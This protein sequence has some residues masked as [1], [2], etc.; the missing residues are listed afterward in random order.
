MPELAGRERCTGCTACA[1]VCLVSC[2]RMER[3][4]EGFLQP[5]AGDACIGCGACERVC[6][7][8]N[9]IEGNAVD[10]QEAVAA[11]CRDEGLWQ[12]S[13]SGGAFTC[14]CEEFAAM[15][16]GVETVVYGAS[17]QFPEVRHVRC[18]ASDVAPLRK[19][20]YVQSDKGDALRRVRDD[21]KAGRR[22]VFS[23]T[24]CEVAALYSYLGGLAQSEDILLVDLVCHG[25]GSPAVFERCMERASARM[26]EVTGYEFRCKRPVAGNYERYLSMYKYL[27]KCLNAKTKYVRVD[28]YNRL[29]L[30]QACLRRSCMERC[31]FRDRRRFGDVT[32]ADLNGKGD[33]YPEFDDGRG[34]ST[35]VGNT[36]KG[37]FV[38]ARLGGSMEVL[39]SSPDD[40]ARY[41][42]LFDHTTPGNP[43]RDEFF[44][45]FVAGDDLGGLIDEYGL[46]PPAKAAL[47][48][49]VPRGIKSAIK[50][51]LRVVRR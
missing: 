21:L 38:I 31:R 6:P 23:G 17:M 18:E 37:R 35:I 28:E 12:K 34:W 48:M 11:V 43:R 47:M 19:S 10:G 44:A 46:R 4:D 33:L 3:D 50:R 51:V 8:L 27:D 26:G 22:V 25:A 49:H 9:G 45:R 42:P 2:I 39:P 5:A 40:V 41:N 20:K 15:A 24:A 30:S 16:P 36:D 13:T 32:L 7:I 1:A 29:F 14:L